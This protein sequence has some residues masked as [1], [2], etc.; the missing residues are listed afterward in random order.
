MTERHYP[1]KL[2]IVP[3]KKPPH[4][5]IR[6]PGS[7]SI[8]NRALVLAALSEPGDGSE[9]HN[10]ADCEDSHIMVAALRDLGFKTTEDWASAKIRVWRERDTRRIPAR[11]A[12]LI[13]GNS[14]TSIR[15]LTALVCLGEGKFEL[16]GVTRMRDRPIGDL[17]DAL[18][19]LGVRRSIFR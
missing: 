2:E 3:L 1:D 16:D 8:T 12:S 4:A 15:F 11:A 14:G 17:L 9:I 18:E 10:V 19:Q 7:K 5:T 13:L 6:V